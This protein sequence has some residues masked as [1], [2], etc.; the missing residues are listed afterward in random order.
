[1]NENFFKLILLKE[2]LFVWNK[3]RETKKHIIL[4]VLSLPTKSKTKN[5]YSAIA[6]G[7]VREVGDTF[8]SR[9]MQIY[10]AS[11]E[12]IWPK[13]SFKRDQKFA[14]FSSNLA[15]NFT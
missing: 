10:K 11:Q 5:N 15:Q 1:M 7:S 14:Q 13:I 12:S 8:F 4:L 6:T 9:G 3:N 2:F